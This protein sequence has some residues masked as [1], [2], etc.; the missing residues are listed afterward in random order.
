MYS[1]GMFL[2]RYTIGVHHGES[3]V[4]DKSPSWWN[5]LISFHDTGGI[6][7][8]TIKSYG[9]AFDYDWEEQMKT[10]S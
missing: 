8:V 5:L 1:A 4:V 7:L 3:G 6:H 9:K 2:S 10:L